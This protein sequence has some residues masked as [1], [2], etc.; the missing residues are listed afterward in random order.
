MFEIDV[1][2][3]SQRFQKG[4]CFLRHSTV[5][6][7]LDTCNLYREYMDIVVKSKESQD[8]Q[9]L[10]MDFSTMMYLLGRAEGKQS[11]RKKRK[12]A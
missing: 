12:G 2:D 4:F 7:F 5:R 3:K 8:W 1:A 9:F 6:L 10:M 11:E